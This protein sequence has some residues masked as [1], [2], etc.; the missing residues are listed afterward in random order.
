[1]LPALIE[2]L[3]GL[4]ER[5]AEGPT[6]APEAPAAEQSSPAAAPAVE[7]DDLPWVN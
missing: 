4:H 1:M 2:A 7:A 3:G 6:A 5:Q